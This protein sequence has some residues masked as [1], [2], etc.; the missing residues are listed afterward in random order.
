MQ[1]A[2]YVTFGGK[3]EVG[4]WDVKMK[5]WVRVQVAEVSK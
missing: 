3:G 5:S 2:R 4:L 1:L